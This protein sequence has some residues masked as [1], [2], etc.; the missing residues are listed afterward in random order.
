MSKAGRTERPTE[1]ASSLSGP[2]WV[3][4]IVP[5]YRYERLWLGINFLLTVSA[6]I[7]F[8]WRA[9]FMICLTA[10]VCLVAYSLIALAIHLIGSGR[11]S[12]G[13]L[14]AALNMGL[15]MGLT[16]PLMPYAALS[17]IAGMLVGGLVHVMGQTHRL[18][19]H[20]VAVAHVVLMMTIPLIGTQQVGAVLTP[21]RIVVGDVWRFTSPAGGP[22]W[23]H[24]TAPN[25]LDA[26]DMAGPS[27]FDA[28]RRADPQRVMHAE[29]KNILRHGSRMVTLLRS[30]ELPRLLDVLIGAAPGP[31][32]GTS[33]VLLI[34]SG[35]WLIYRRVGRWAPALTALAA[36][37]ICL[38][39]LPVVSEGQVVMSW[40]CFSQ[41]GWKVTVAYF[42]YQLLATP[43]LL[44][45]LLL[46]PLTMPRTSRG[47]IWYA[48]IIGAGAVSARWV[49]PI[50]WVS[51]LPLIVAGLMCPILDRM[52]ESVFVRR[53]E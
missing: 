25:K 2:P 8:G 46:A 3:G 4:P 5:L 9:L 32:G 6:T 53:R 39:I 10:S 51:Y 18:R 37:M 50:E 14:S 42:A 13:T 45:V 7:F 38:L 23:I 20:P 11:S 17:V 19:A 41:V 52:R 15:L 43:L 34:L 1:A 48:V 24:M 47:R 40:Q 22:T 27:D 35:L 44:I 36:A 28:V 29:Q 31:V 30:G 12:E 21:S 33:A 16:L 26:I 49:V